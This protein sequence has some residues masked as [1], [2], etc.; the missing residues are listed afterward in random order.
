[1][2]LKNKPN[3]KIRRTKMSNYPNQR[4]QN[5]SPYGG[6]IHY[7]GVPILET[8]PTQ[9]QSVLFERYYGPGRDILGIPRIAGY[10]DNV[11]GYDVPHWVVMITDALLGQ[12]NAGTGLASETDPWVQSVTRHLIP[13]LMQRPIHSIWSGDVHLNPDDWLDDVLIKRFLDRAQL[14]SEELIRVQANPVLRQKLQTGESLTVGEYF[15]VIGEVLS[16]PEDFNFIPHARQGLVKYLPSVEGF[17]RWSAQQAL[18]EQ[19]NLGFNHPMPRAFVD[20][21]AGLSP[22]ALADEFGSGGNNIYHLLRGFYRDWWTEGKAHRGQKVAVIGGVASEYTLE[23]L[24]VMCFDLDFFTVVMLPWCG[25]MGVDSMLN[26]VEKLTNRYGKKMLFTFDWLPT[27]QFGPKPADFD[28][29]A[30][31]MRSA[32]YLEEFGDKSTPLY[33]AYQPLV[34]EWGKITQ[35]RNHIQDQIDAA[36]NAGRIQDAQRL[37]QQMPAPP[38][39]AVERL[40]RALA[41]T[42]L[43]GASMFMST[44]EIV[45]YLRAGGIV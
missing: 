37:E 7:P 23:A 14:S 21:K 34:D 1:L 33:N 3:Q 13:A 5:R 42:Q 30:Q 15:E 41:E 9:I 39:M 44:N 40:V 28:S 10:H 18:I 16:D 38:P 8:D 27:N 6:G 11:L 25:T 36:Y 45:D 35:E 43:T 26:M 29:H 22:I 31:M 24:A 2:Y 12:Q 17:L 4:A 19:N 32:M 20:H